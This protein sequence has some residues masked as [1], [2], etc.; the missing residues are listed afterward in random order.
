VLSGEWSFDPAG[1]SEKD[2]CMLS[3][4]AIQI[5]VPLTA[6][7]IR[8]T[9]RGTAG[10][11]TT[12]FCSRPDEEASATGISILHS[13]NWSTG[14]WV[15]QCAYIKRTSIDIA[16]PDRRIVNLF[17]T[18][19]DGNIKITLLGPVETLT[20]EAIDVSEC[21]DEN[22]YR[23]AWQSARE[24]VLPLR[25]STKIWREAVLKPRPMYVSEIISLLK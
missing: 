23:D 24:G 6:I 1:G 19:W 21:P 12:F 9:C 18:P 10:T 8:V 7:P 14:N 20:V 3:S 13:K 4:A 17:S 11:K 5:D 25:Y 15:E 2:G 22:F 16:C